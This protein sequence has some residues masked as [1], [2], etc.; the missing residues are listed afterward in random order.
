MKNLPTTSSDDL[1]NWCKKL[2]IKLKFIGCKNDLDTLKPVNGC[3]II[4][5]LDS[6]NAIDTIGHWVGFYKHNNYSVY[7]DSFGVYPPDNVVQFLEKSKLI[8]YNNQQIQDIDASYCGFISVMFLYYM[9]KVNTNKTIDKRLELF[10]NI[11]SKVNMKLNKKFI[12]QFFNK[13]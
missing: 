9:T 10:D 8:Y 2:N 5:M 1:I 13:H 11:F 12:L 3:Y 6:T 4:N 7:F